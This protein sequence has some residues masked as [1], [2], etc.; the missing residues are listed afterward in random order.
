MQSKPKSHNKLAQFIRDNKKSHFSNALILSTVLSACGKETKVVIEPEEVVTVTPEPEPA[1]PLPPTLS[2]GVNYLGE[3][4]N[5]DIISTTYDVLK[6]IELVK[7]ANTDDN[8]QLN[9]TTNQNISTTPLISG[10]ETVNFY[11]SNVASSVEAIFNLKDISDFQTITFTDT[12]E[13][14][15]LAKI[16][17]LNSSGK[18]VFADNYTDID[19]YSTIGANIQ[20]ETSANSSVSV[21]NQ[22]GTLTINGGGKSLAVDT[23]NLGLIDISNNSSI[24]LEAKS[25]KDSI[26]LTSNGD[27]SVTDA[28]FLKGNVTV[29]AIGNIEIND[30]RSA[31][32]KLDLENLRAAPGKDITIKNANLVKSAEIKSTGAVN[33]FLNGG[34][35]GAETINVTAA[36]NSKLNAQSNI[37]KTVVLNANNSLNTEVI[38]DVDIDGMT[39]LTLGGSAPILLIAPGDNLDKTVVTSTN[40]SGAIIDIKSANTDVSNVATNIML[41]LPNLDGKIITVGNN[42]NLAIDTEVTQTST[43]GITEYHF[44]TAA[45]ASSSNT[46]KI[47]TVD[48]DPTNIDNTANLSGLKLKDVQHLNISLPDGKGINTVKNIEGTEL[49]TVTLTGSGDFN[50]IDK[51][52]VGVPDGSVSLVASALSGKLSV[53][54]NN[55]ANSVKSVIAGSGDDNINIDSVSSSLSSDGRGINVEGR[56]GHDVFSFSENSDGRSAKVVVKGGSGVDKATFAAGVDFSL[57]DFTISGI[58]E[59][60]FTGGSSNV[61]LPSTAV[62]GQNINISENG[63]GNLTL[64]IFP[65]AQTVNVSSLV[66]DSSIVSGT[67]KIVVNGSNYTKALTVTGSTIGDEI[68]GTFTSNDTISSGFGNDTI[69]GRDGNDVLTPG[70]GVD[71]IT[72]GLGNDTINLAELIAATDTLNYSIDDGSSNVDIVS[73][74]DMRIADDIISLDVSATSKPITNGNASAATAAAKGT[75]RVHEQAMDENA[76]DASRSIAQIIKLTQT[77]KGNFADALGTGEVTVAN[78]A[79]LCFLWYDTDVDQAV[80][81][82]SD[83]TTAAD[84]DN[85]ITKADT[86]V[87][88]VRLNMTES[89]YTHFLDTD[90]FVF[91]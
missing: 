66:F 28:P 25:A 22:A 91:V 57:S 14:A 47:T 84:S 3:T 50:L 80:F 65:T 46:V 90:N 41:R 67:D 54:I 2:A 59:F 18:L 40:S 77:D 48:T 53:N 38:Y 64:E 26:K 11:T 70:D 78:G 49:K 72:P 74:F 68:T 62:S 17:I 60:E 34:L 52:I 39:S 86:F 27:V 75:I 35:K 71:Q 89:S 12:S 83:E 8:D 10:F 9:I 6:T 87:E 16:S 5:D 55:T 88:I 85:K 82:Y 81:G 36:E 43:S 24:I 51:T 31:T 61:K 37:S 73:N 20:V 23:A 63:S 76:N 42:Q 45:T 30:V 44:A 58:E 33:A 19:I 21:L 7:D 13:T 32:G 79:V 56:E 4:E 15:K 1:A 69:N 29:S